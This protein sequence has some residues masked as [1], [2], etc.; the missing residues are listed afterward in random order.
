M[1]NSVYAK[2]LENLQ[3]DREM[4]NIGRKQFGPI[5]DSNKRH[6]VLKSFSER[7]RHMHRNPEKRTKANYH[8]T[9]YDQDSMF[10]GIDDRSCFS[11]LENYR[12]MLYFLRNNLTE[13]FVLEKQIPF[14][15]I[16]GIK[17]D[18][19][20]FLKQCFAINTHMFNSVPGGLAY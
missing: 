12:I 6:I 8:S 18:G 2:S 15:W 11:R 3:F 16:K 7:L 20:V 13:K 9:V 4:S 10:Y 1:I 17:E 5:R 19:D 14:L